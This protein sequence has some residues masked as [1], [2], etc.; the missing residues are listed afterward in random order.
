MAVIEESRTYGYK[1]SEDSNYKKLSS[2]NANY[3]FNKRN[4]PYKEFNYII[5]SDRIAKNSH[6]YF[7]KKQK[8][9][10]KNN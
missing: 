4:E 3:I 5:R 8:K 1:V 7:A 10:S 6:S 9:Q 2:P